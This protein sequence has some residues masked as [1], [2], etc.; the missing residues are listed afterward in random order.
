M[1]A[2]L[3]DEG[4]VS[5]IHFDYQSGKKLLLTLIDEDIITVVTGFF[6]HNNSLACG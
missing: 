1:D 2:H 3:A 4:Q 5:S 6:A